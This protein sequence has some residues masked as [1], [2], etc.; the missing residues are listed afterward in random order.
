LWHQGE[1]DNA[2][3]TTA[4]D[5]RQRLETVIAQ[6]RTDA[7]YEIPWG[8]AQVSYLP[9]L[10]PASDPDILAAQLQVVDNDPLSFLG[11]AT[12]DLIN[13]G[14]MTWRWDNVHFN[15]AGLREHARRWYDELLATFDFVQLV[16]DFDADDDVDAHD[17]AALSTGF[18]LASGAKLADGD[19]DADQDTDGADFFAWQR[20]FRKSAGSS[21]SGN[22]RVP[23]PSSLV[24]LL[25]GAMAAAGAVGSNPNDTR[26]RR[27]KQQ[28]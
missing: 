9:N 1:S 10:N 14:D 21:A 6:S 19:A 23:E 3:S 17:L 12:D 4:N 15:E 8:I 27:E 5:Y 28:G 7:G 2:S 26:G 18:G 24:L 20:N 16:A 13:D 22:A 25:I 11:A